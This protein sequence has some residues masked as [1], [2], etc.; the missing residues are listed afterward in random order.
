MKTKKVKSG[1]PSSSYLNGGSC[2]MQKRQSS[3]R[4]L[5]RSAVFMLR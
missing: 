1:K 3:T 5:V 2:D 4:N